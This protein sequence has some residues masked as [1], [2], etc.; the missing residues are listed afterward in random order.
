[1]KAS[2]RGKRRRRRRGYI[3][4]AYMDF[5]LGYA[6]DGFVVDDGNAYEAGHLSNFLKELGFY[7]GPTSVSSY[8]KDIAREDGT[9]LTSP[10]TR[11][12]F[13]TSICF[14]IRNFLEFDRISFLYLRVNF[15]LDQEEWDG[16]IYDDGDECMEVG[17]TEQRME[18][19]KS[20]VICWVV[21]LVVGWFV[22]VA[23]CC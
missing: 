4:L 12:P 8:Y 5:R 7:R 23:C 18:E 19:Q 13:A 21:G 22:V 9:H 11:T 1:M 17:F 20:Y 15:S 2:R 16:E 14:L 6:N 3:N 10:L